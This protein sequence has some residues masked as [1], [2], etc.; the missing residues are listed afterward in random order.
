MKQTIS[1]LT[2]A[3]LLIVSARGIHA[4]SKSDT[5]AIQALIE[6]E[7]MAW[8]K[9]DAVAYS[10]QFAQKG[11]FTN[12]QGMFFMGHEVFMQRHE[13]IFKTVFSKTV[14]QLKMVAL[15]FVRPDVAVVETLS[16]VSGFAGDPPPGARLDA[17]GRLITRLLQVVVK[18]S[19]DWKIV[20]YHNVD[21]KP[22][23]LI[24]E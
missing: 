4:Q 17:K 2:L 1:T 7:V 13:Q 12:I 9:G 23:V 19:A 21:V 14:L 15:Q 10:R 5:V 6:N 18:E 3:L 22:G 20:A 8:N 11:T 16:M 24:P